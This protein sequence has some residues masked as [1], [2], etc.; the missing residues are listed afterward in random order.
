ME[1]F[2]KK[3]PLFLDQVERIMACTRCKL[4]GLCQHRCPGLGNL[5]AKV[6]F[7]GE[8][9]GRVENP[10]LR[11]LP[12]VG[13][14]SSDLLLDVVYENWEHGYDDVFI[15]NVVKCNP[16]ENRKPE[17][18]EIKACLPFLQEEVGLVKPKVIVALGRTAANTFDVKESLN[19]ARWK[20]YQWKG[21]LVLV[22]FHPAY[23]LRFGGLAEKQYHA[24][25]RIMKR[26]IDK[27]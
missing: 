27:E 24:E 7:I 11:E 4:S 3:D 22:K 12:F 13:N 17:E 9:P 19:T 10:D 21:C 26:R 23:I 14:R 16:P 6:M 8:A 20:E 2:I 15:T 5:N 25:F 1:R 18:E